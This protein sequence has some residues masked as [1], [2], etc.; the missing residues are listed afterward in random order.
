[1]S[2]CDGF[3]AEKG[4]DGIDVHS[5]S[6]EAHSEGVAEAVEGY[7]LLNLGEF[8]ESGNVETQFITTQI[9]EYQA[10]LFGFAKQFDC[11]RR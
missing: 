10:F 9:G 2:A 7:V 6:Q 4:G 11:R 8:E 3:V 1:M 5:V